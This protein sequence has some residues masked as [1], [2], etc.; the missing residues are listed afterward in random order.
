M[1]S[2]NNPVDKLLKISP[3]LLLLILL[4]A[5]PDGNTENLDWLTLSLVGLGP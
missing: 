2:A 3:T 1:Y 5:G 4:K